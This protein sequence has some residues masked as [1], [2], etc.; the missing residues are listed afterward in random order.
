MRASLSIGEDLSAGQIAPTHAD[1]RVASAGPASAGGPAE[2]SPID[3]GAAATS[4]SPRKRIRRGDAACSRNEA[5]DAARSRGGSGDAARMLRVLAGLTLAAALAAF[6][7]GTTIVGKAALGQALLKRAWRESRATGA[8]VK[9][10]PW[11]DTHPVARL[12]SVAHDADVIVL[13]GATG[14]T[15]AWGPGQLDGS[16][17]PGDAG[18]TVFTAH[19]DTHFAFLAHVQRGDVLDVERVDG[20][21]VRYR[22]RAMAIVDVGSLA[23][24]AHGD[25]PTLTLVTCYP[26]D[27]IAPNTPLRYVV[28]ATIE[29]PAAGTAGA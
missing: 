20:V 15:L 23:L 14:R 24:R 9:P 26:F 11:A 17:R 12:R 3:S 18:N 19:R 8:E 13:A 27:A 22:V 16:A 4:R 2:S 28:S 7:W 21:H 1:D 10:W 25:A 29:A 5:V 6:A